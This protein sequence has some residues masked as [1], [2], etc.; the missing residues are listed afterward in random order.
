HPEAMTLTTPAEPT[1]IDVPRGLKGVVA[2]STAIGD[3]Q[4][5][6]GFYH[7]RQYSAIDLV[8][9]C[10]LDEVW[11]LVL[12]GSLPT[13]DE[14]ARFRAEVR[15]ARETPLPRSVVDALPILA[16]ASGA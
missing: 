3:V 15:A 10:T 11:H 9:H 6:A 1:L 5:R 7:Y 14:L 13:R 16:A 4:G 2:A 12:D 8:E